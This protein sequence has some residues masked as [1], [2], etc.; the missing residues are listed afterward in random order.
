M[1]IKLHPQAEEDLK[2]ALN[3]YSKIDINLEKRFID[4][5]E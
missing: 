5:L 2:E 1:E 4:S 3:Y